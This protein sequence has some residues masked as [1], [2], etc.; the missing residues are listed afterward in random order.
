M[1]QKKSGHIVNISSAAGFLGTPFMAPYNAS[2]WG[3][4]GLTESLKLEMEELGIPNI[5]FTLVCP[6]YVDTGMFAGV[7]A[8]IL[9]PLLKPER[10]VDIA[11]RAF[12]KNRYLVLEPFIVKFVPLL[13]GILSNYLF[14]KVA[15]ILGVTRSMAGWHGKR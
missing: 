5:H 7:R 12:R 1:I 2:K 13:R 6:S 11:Y 3:V 15:K 4:I 9:V 14:G 8:P 10:I